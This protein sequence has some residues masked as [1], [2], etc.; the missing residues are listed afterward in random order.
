ME[1]FE[2]HNNPF[3]H[4]PFMDQRDT[5][6]HSPLIIDDYFFVLH[7]GID[8]EYTSLILDYF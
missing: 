6:D 1:F 5:I 4:A 3:P 8:H 2:S 7:P